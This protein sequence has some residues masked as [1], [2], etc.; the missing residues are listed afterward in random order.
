[1]FAMKLAARHR[2]DPKDL[3]VAWRPSPRRADLALAQMIP[4][5]TRCGAHRRSELALSGD[6]DG[7]RPLRY[8]LAA[9]FSC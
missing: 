9:F 4:L 1:M 7:H 5:E 6:K 8:I 3:H 2:S